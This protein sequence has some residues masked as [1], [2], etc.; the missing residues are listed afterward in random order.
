MM[1]PHQLSMD[2][3]GRGKCSLGLYG[4]QPWLGNCVGCAKAGENNEEFAKEL[5]ARRTKSHPPGAPAASGCCDDARNPAID[6][7]QRTG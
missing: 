3:T 2:K 6:V 7:I 4:G 5:L 1:C